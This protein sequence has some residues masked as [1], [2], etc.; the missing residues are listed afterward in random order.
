MKPE[1]PGPAE[2]WRR[3]GA[4][5]AESLRCHETLWR[6]DCWHRLFPHAQPATKRSRVTLFRVRLSQQLQAQRG[7]QAVPFE[8]ASD[9]APVRVKQIDRR[10]LADIE[11]GGRFGEVSGI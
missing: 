3:S 7:E 10:Q 11:R 2:K 4:G 1:A 5:S 9:D 6:N 8:V